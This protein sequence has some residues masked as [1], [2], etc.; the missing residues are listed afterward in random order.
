[1]GRDRSRLEV[2]TGLPAK[3][4][5]TAVFAIPGVF[6]G[7]FFFYP[8]VTIFWE[9]LGS[10]GIS[11]LAELLASSRNRNV[12]WF[13]VWQA[14]VSTTLTII[15][16]L[17]AAALLARLR[18]KKQLWLRGLVTVPFVLPTV[19][20]AGAFEGLFFRF[21]LDSGGFRLRHTFWAILLAHIFLNYAVV[22]RIVGS[23]WAGLD[24]RI[25]EQAR[26]LGA[27]KLRVFWM[28]TLPR[29]RPTLASAAA[30]VFLF[31]F[32]S[33]GV[34]LLLG[35][36]R[37]AT[38]ETEIYRQ[39]VTRGDLQVAATLAFVQLLFVM[40]IVVVATILERRQPAPTGVATVDRK[41]LSRAFIGA[42][43]AVMLFLLGLPIALLVEGSFAV[44]DGYGFRHYQALIERVPQLPASAF[45][46]LG[47]SLVFAMLATSLALV[48]GSLTTFFVVHSRARLPKVLDLGATLPLG[49]SAVTIGFG[50][51]ITLDAPPVDFRTSWWIIP[52]A[53]ALVGVPFV[54]RCMVPTMRRIDP[55]LREAAALLG[56]SPT[57]V[58]LTV[59][60]PIVGRAMLVGAGFAFTVSLGEFGAT[61]FLPRNPD[62]LTA[63]LALFRLLSTPG[64]L[65]RGQAM[66]LTVV[67][68]ITVTLVVVAIE[69][70]RDREV[71]FL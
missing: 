39:A 48:V 22:V 15:I 5:R 50:I 1:M 71:T 44:G 6:F 59:D 33:F 62:T 28:V 68:M 27:G 56:A 4:V 70:L 13:T 45:Q 26:V 36:P 30:I 10:V 47:N 7:V 24:H 18:G 2:S 54:L 64:E 19:V 61:S 34:V 17:P 20:V 35:G 37:R 42:N 49:V 52:I 67:L 66:A 58:R 40:L 38:L 29:L 60:L 16:A 46:A 63:P 14:L 32:T 23:F 55:Q 51:L 31:S 9:G 11:R 53:H 41:P 57:R 12:I 8:L 69:A 65:L 21:G 43:L 3:A 25:E